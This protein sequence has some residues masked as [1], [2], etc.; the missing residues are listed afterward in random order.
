MENVGIIQLEQCIVN[1]VDNIVDNLAGRGESL[2]GNV[3][4]A[5]PAGRSIRLFPGFLDSLFAVRAPSRH[6]GVR[7]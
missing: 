3:S 5:Q 6:K 2:G 1:M 7:R 4:G